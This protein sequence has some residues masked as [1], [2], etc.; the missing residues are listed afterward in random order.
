MSWCAQELKSMPPPWALCAPPEFRM[1][2]KVL[3][4]FPLR[5]KKAA[6]ALGRKASNLDG[7][8]S[9]GAYC[10]SRSRFELLKVPY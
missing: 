10:K 5:I 8:S 2:T 7:H 6:L 3:R 4:F 9:P 1:V